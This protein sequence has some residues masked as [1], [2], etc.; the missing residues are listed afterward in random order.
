MMPT[1]YTS[2]VLSRFPVALLALALHGG[3]GKA[4]GSAVKVENPV[5]P[6]ENTARPSADG[7]AGFEGMQRPAMLY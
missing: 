4:E 2:P 1:S 5:P 7:K 6:L 3:C